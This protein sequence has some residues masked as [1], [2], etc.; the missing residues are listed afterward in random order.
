MDASIGHVE[1]T[2][3]GGHGLCDQLRELTTAQHVHHHRA[4]HPQRAVAEW[5]TQHATQ[6]LLELVNT[7]CLH[8]V[9]TS[10]VRPRGD[11]VQ[12]NCPVVEEE[13]LDAED[14]SCIPKAGDGIRGHFLCQ[15]LHGCGD[16]QRRRH[17]GEAYAVT[18]HG[19]HHR[20]SL[21]GDIHGPVHAACHHNCQLH[22]VWG[23]LLHVEHF[24]TEAL[25]GFLDSLRVLHHRV[26]LAVVGAEAAL[27]HHRIAEALAY[28]V[29]ICLRPHD[30]EVG[31][32]HP[33]FLKVHL[34]EVLV[35]DEL[36]HRRQWVYH[37]P[38]LV[39]L[40][41]RLAVHVLYFHGQH[42]AS[43]RQLRDGLCI[44]EAARNRVLCHLPCG[45]FCAQGVQDHHAHT[46]PVGCLH[47]HA[48][49]LPAS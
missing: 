6:V 22:F 40:L 38:C 32:R 5:Q 49:Q 14:T 8:G 26:A 44:L 28:D 36:D 42:S 16:T 25:H 30:L 31:Q 13:E 23:P 46:Q 24:A 34:L 48:P 9:V 12:Q 45:R 37:H 35:L 43:T 1:G 18:L 15:L 21:Y 7:T 17:A 47:H 11:F 10:V 19:M 20:V 27:E 39:K 33:S 2:H 41:Q 4:A 3:E 29:Q